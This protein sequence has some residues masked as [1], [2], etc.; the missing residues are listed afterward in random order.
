MTFERFLQTEHDLEIVDFAQR[1]M[2]ETRKMIGELYLE[3]LRSLNN[4]M[5]ASR[6]LGFLDGLEFTKEVMAYMHMAQKVREE[7]ERENEPEV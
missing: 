7:A 4:H 3:Y 6:T 5:P 2:I 1:G